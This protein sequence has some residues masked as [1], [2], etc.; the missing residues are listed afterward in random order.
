MPKLRR[1]SFYYPAGFSSGGDKVHLEIAPSGTVPLEMALRYLRIQPSR[2]E[3]LLTGS[4]NDG[5]VRTKAYWFNLGERPSG[6]LS[7]MRCSCLT[8]LTCTY[9]ANSRGIVPQSAAEA[10]LEKARRPK[11]NRTRRI[12]W[13]RRQR[14][15]SPCVG[16]MKLL[17]RGK[18]SQPLAR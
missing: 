11:A 12:E 18:R 3:H 14:M 13:L 1:W 10:S 15:K 8:W 5:W 6:P 4:G 9:H 17:P 16:A 7:P 2:Q